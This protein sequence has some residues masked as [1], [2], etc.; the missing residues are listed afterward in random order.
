MN[1]QRSLQEPPNQPDLGG[2]V[3]NAGANEKNLVAHINNVVAW[4][5]HPG[6]AG[7]NGPVV[8]FLAGPFPAACG[9]TDGVLGEGTITPA[10]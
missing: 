5:I 10:S 7:V 9:R 8:A 2:P 1:D 6:V 4:H 3:R